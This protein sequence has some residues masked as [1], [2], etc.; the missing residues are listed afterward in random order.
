MTIGRDASDE[1]VK[2]AKCCMGSYYILFLTPPENK[3]S[4]FP[5]GTFLMNTE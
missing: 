4:P 3:K 2:S 1:G 5:N